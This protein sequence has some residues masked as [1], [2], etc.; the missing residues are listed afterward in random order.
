MFTLVIGGA[1][2]GKSEYAEAHVETL[3]GRRLYIA[4][5]EPWD[6][7]CRARIARHQVAR[8]HKRFTTVECYRNLSQLTVPP[9]SNV[10]L[11]CL[12]NL[13]ANE[14]YGRQGGGVAQAVAGVAHLLRQCRHVTVVTNEVFSSGEAYQGDTLSYLRD[15][16]WANRT[17]ARRADQVVELV[18]G[19]PCVW[20]GTE[21]WGESWKLWRWH[22]P[23][24]PRFPCPR[25]PGKNGI[26]G[27]RCVPSLWW[28][29]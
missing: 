16:A 10:L 5:M 23:C 29:G 21:G 2:S 9:D 28:E 4:T 1:A 25:F 8:A 6:E 15:L 11:E 18:C 3:P 22:F 19:L 13:V 20:K 27:M 24:S 12:G 17:L 14:R 26:C 7:E